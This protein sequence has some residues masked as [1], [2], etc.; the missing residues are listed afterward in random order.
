MSIVSLISR[1]MFVASYLQ[2]T[3]GPCSPLSKQTLCA[4]AKVAAQAQ[5]KSVCVMNSP[6][7]DTAMRHSKWGEA[8]GEGL[9]WDSCNSSRNELRGRVGE[10]KEEHTG[11]KQCSVTQH[12]ILNYLLLEKNRIGSLCGSECT[13]EIWHLSI[14]ISNIILFVLLLLTTF[15]TRL[16]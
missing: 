14:Q 10:M 5:S 6:H 8:G 15:I 1:R 16:F 2:L 12:V 13:F 9:Q 4:P 3:D 11:I 7:F